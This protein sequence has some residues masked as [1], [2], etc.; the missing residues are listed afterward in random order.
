MYQGIWDFVN[1]Y[2]MGCLRVWGIVICSI[3]L[4]SYILTFYINERVWHLSS[5]SMN[6]IQ[7]H[8]QNVSSTYLCQCCV[9]YRNG[10]NIHFVKVLKVLTFYIFMR[11]KVDFWI[12]QKIQ[13]LSFSLKFKTK[14]QILFWF[15]HLIWRWYS[16]CH[17]LV[18]LV[19]FSLSQCRKH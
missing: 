4:L 5:S 2:K 16:L 11:S 6:I 10:W 14:F 13:S 15:L 9:T 1:T 7:T 18:W 12:R 17:K 3:E 8:L 19:R